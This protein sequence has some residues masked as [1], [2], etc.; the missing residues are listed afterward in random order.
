MKGNINK[1]YLLII[2]YFLGIIS[3]IL[4]FVIILEVGYYIFILEMGKL[5]SREVS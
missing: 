2:D 3:K 4:F 5:R 1:E